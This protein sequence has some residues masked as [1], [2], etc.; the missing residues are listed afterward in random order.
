MTHVLDFDDALSVDEDPA[1]AVAEGSKIWPGFFTDID[2][3]WRTADWSAV[4]YA[5]RTFHVIDART[6][7]FAPPTARRP[8]VSIGTV[9]KCGWQ[10]ILLDGLP[11]G[12]SLRITPSGNVLLSTPNHGTTTHKGVEAALDSWNFVGIQLDRRNA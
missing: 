11:C 4:H 5:P 1:F 6:G 3:A 9:D 7:E 12:A 8:D 2:A 10:G